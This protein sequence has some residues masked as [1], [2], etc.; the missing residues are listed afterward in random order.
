MI[1][2]SEKNHFGL[3]A[4]VGSH[5][6]MLKILAKNDNDAISV[7]WKSNSADIGAK[8]AM[9]FHTLAMLDP[10]RLHAWIASTPHAWW[11]PDNSKPTAQTTTK[12]NAA[13]VSLS[14]S[15][16]YNS[17][18]GGMLQYLHQENRSVFIELF[19]KS[20]HL[21]NSPSCRFY[22]DKWCKDLAPH[23]LEKFQPL[24]ATQPSSWYTTNPWRVSL[25]T[26]TTGPREENLM[27]AAAVAENG[28]LHPL[29]EEKYPGVGTCISL[30]HG[31]MVDT[32]QK[33]RFLR[34]WLVNQMGPHNN[35]M[36][37]ELTAA[38]SFELFD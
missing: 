8:K 34:N 9:L 38:D 30:G 28:V 17:I 20:P 6:A 23:H 36:K 16:R 29:L 10:T 15:D 22:L 18:A 35:A 32:K 14:I 4:A 7:F 31:L 37:L 27:L 21:F 24:L 13:Y 25:L 11:S 5:M 1:K 3:S 2:N 12:T 26:S 19:E 33:K